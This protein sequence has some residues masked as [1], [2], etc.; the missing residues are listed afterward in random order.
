[1]EGGGQMGDVVVV[2]PVLQ[3]AVRVSRSPLVGAL[4]VPLVGCWDAGAGREVGHA[5]GVPLGGRGSEEW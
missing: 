2:G 1:M 4:V 3:E 5:A